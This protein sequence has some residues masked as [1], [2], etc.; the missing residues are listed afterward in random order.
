MTLDSDK[1]S[2]LRSFNQK[3]TG[4]KFKTVKEVVSWL[5]AIQAQDY[6]MAKWALGIRLQNSTET[7]INNEI[8]SGNI[9]RTH[10]LRP[11]WH[12]VSSEDIYWIQ[13]LTAPQI[14]SSLKFRDKQLGLTDTIFGKCNKL[15]EKT[16]RDG[17]HK[18][19]EELIQELINAKIEVDNNRASHIFLRAEI[20]GII[21][22]GKQKDGKP[23]YAILAEW[24]PIKKRTY[25]DEDLKELALRY[26]TSRGPATIQDFTWW[27]GLSSSKSKL[28]LD[29]NKSNLIF[30]TIENKTYWFVDSY[31]MPKQVN[32]EIYL[33]P[34]FDEFLISYRDRTA[35]LLSIDEKR[36]ISDNGIFYPAILKG[37]QIIGTWKRN[38]KNNHII[39]KL[40]LIKT[41]NTNPGKTYSKPTSR[42]SKF[43]NMEA[44]II[45]NTSYSNK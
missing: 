43:Y 14:K 18:T 36:T 19:R 27:S 12:F 1:I 37:G 2:S 35:S 11:T 16:L 33:L 21:C 45:I 26:F 41:Y 44:E 9:I 15:F 4:S 29:L 31:D 7:V 40:N 42:Y 24:V 13:E 10:L 5:G 23:T 25:I 8:D 30:E 22:S 39:L 28:A 3:I 32:R 6:N 34:A 38:I 20:D 17:N